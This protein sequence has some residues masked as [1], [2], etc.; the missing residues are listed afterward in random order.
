MKKLVPLVIAVLFAYF[1]QE[2]H[3]QSQ[4]APSAGGE[5]SNATS[6]DGQAFRSGA[7]AQG[8]G[9]V[10]RILPDDNVGSR[11]QRFILRMHSGRTLLIAHNINVAQRI[12]GLRVGDTVSFYGIFE[13]NDQGGVIHWTHR[14]P[15]GRHEAG[16]L[17]HNGQTYQ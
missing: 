7:Q 15:A 4:I 3:D 16:W 13:S 1:L 17:K 5:S 2:Q 6:G 10:S 8:S 14:D 11:H 9:I 12:S